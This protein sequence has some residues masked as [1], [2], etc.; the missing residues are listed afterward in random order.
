MYSYVFS[1]FFV[2][3]VL[4]IVMPIVFLS[5]FVLE[6]STSFL[7]WR[8]LLFANQYHKNSYVKDF[9]IFDNRRFGPAC[10]HLD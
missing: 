4:S 2:Q 8:N 9:S 7:F 5:V 1:P 10:A 6:K 3:F